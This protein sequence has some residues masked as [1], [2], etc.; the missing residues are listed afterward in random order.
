VPSQEAAAGGPGL[1]EDRRRWIVAAVAAF[2]TAHSEAWIVVTSRVRPY[3][4]G[5]F[6]LAGWPTFELASLDGG[7]IE[8][9]A[10]RWYAELAAAGRLGAEEARDRR[11]RL[12]GA[13][14]NR[15]VLAGMAKTP[16]LLT[17]LARVN[18]R[19]VL[20]EGRA[21]LYGACVEQLLW[22]WEKRISDE[23]G[24]TSLARLLEAAGCGLRPADFERVLWELTYEVHGR[25]GK[26]TDEISAGRLRE[27]LANLDP[28]LPDP[29]SWADRVLQLLASRGGLLNELDTGV[30]TFPH[31]S[32][33]EYLAARWLLSRPGFAAEARRL[34]AD[35]VWH[36][37]V[38]LA[39]GHLRSQGHFD[40]VEAVA[41]QLVEGPAPRRLADWRRVLLAGRVWEDFG[42][43]RASA[44]T[45]PRLR[46]AIPRLLTRLMQHPKL[47]AGQRLEAGLLAADFGL[48]PPDV[49]ALVRLPADRLEYEFRIGKY[50]VTNAQYRRFVDAGGYDRE[51]PWWSDEAR[52]DMEKFRVGW[53][54][55]P[56]LADERRYNRP[57]LPVVAVSWYEAVAFCVW[58]TG[59]LRRCGAIAGDQ[60]V[61]LPTVAEWA[62]AAAGGEGRRFPWGDRA[63]V[64][65]LN[66]KESGLGGPSP[67]HM[68][69][70]GATPEGVLDLAGNVWEWTADAHPKESE[71]RLLAGGSWW[72][73]EEE[74][75]P[76]AR[77][78][79]LAVDWG[80]LGFR[81]VV[82]PSSRARSW[83]LDSGS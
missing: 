4:E 48:L 6:R 58:R 51:A 61:R 9:F 71:W 75:G 80:G 43:Q 19:S 70:L 11:D 78:G 37:V 13:V 17:M 27:A 21:E 40:A 33:Q 44:A 42:P 77:F 62:R 46:K 73:S 65:R 35:D 54:A 50:P 41:A 39:C 10:H 20:P 45:G 55:E 47:P 1:G 66:C 3:R 38:L 16:L 72:V 15:P 32:F 49:E 30:F 68:Y 60:V 76:A 22:E 57:S 23:G 36:E 53:P 18:T 2:A 64:H 29:W 24:V 79:L 26:E 52:R 28:K 63:E 31:R 67:V 34:A 8:R 74:C 81:V 69:P 5:G 12:L 25:S 82:V 83:M 7:R 14:R 56:R 59:E